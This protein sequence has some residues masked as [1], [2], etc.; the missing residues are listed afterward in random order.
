[1]LSKVELLSL[2]RSPHPLL[3][4]YSDLEAQLQPNGFDLTVREV[5]VYASSGQMPAGVAL[6]GRAGTVALPFDEDGRLPLAP[7]AY[8]ISFNEVVALLL[9]VMAI[10]RPRS[11]LLRCGAAVHT[12]VWDAGYRGRS[13]ALLSVLNPSGLSLA[14]DAR[15]VQMVFMC[16]ASPGKVGYSGRYLGE[17]L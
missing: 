7:G 13:Q 12:G 2:I 15:V 4:G 10:A 5:F 8:L 17:N 11:S 9:N 6:S 1:M 3:E 16:L 14:R